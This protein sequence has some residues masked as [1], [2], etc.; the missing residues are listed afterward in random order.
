MIVNSSGQIMV[1]TVHD[2]ERVPEVWHVPR[3]ERGSVSD[4]RESRRQAAG[5]PGESRAPVAAVDLPCPVRSLD[6]MEGN[7]AGLQRGAAA[8]A[9]D[10]SP[11]L[12]RDARQATVPGEPGSGRGRRWL[13]TPV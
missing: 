3:G 1:K 13:T 8:A 11:A 4:A 9:A 10:L 6:D 7:R 5:V 2:H 12:S